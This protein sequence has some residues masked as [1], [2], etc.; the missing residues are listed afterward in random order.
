MKNVN[1]ISNYDLE[2]FELLKS[3]NSILNDDYHFLEND[4]KTKFKIDLK[5][6]FSKNTLKNDDLELILDYVNKNSDEEIIGFNYEIMK[7]K[8]TKD[9]L[10]F[11]NEK[12]DVL[13][14]VE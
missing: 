9:V 12:I 1:I 6:Q 7:R 14:I 2:I 3:D 4:C 10:E 5:N 11:D 13:K 8:Y